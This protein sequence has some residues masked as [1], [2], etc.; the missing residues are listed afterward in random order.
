MSLKIIARELYQLE[1]E[2]SKLENQF[3]KTPLMERENLRD[4]IR[5]VK[6]QRDYMRG[7][8]EGAKDPPPYRRPR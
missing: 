8:I 6:A 2:L 5:K 4:E 1:T 3:E 7:L